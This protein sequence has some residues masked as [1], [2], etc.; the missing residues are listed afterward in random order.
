MNISKETTYRELHLIR[1]LNENDRRVV[2]INMSGGMANAVEI[3]VKVLQLPSLSQLGDIYMKHKEEQAVAQQVTTIVN[4]ATD[5]VAN[6]PSWNTGGK[7]V[8]ES[9]A[10]P[11]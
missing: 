2:G 10:I 9:Y 8:N 1:G 4:N 3:C 7:E 11:L 5:A 6:G